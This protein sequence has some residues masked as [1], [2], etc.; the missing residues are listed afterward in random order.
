MKLLE[1]G[2]YRLYLYPTLLWGCVRAFDDPNV[3]TIGIGPFE[4]LIDPADWEETENE[5]G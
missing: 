4:L 3:W 2:R 5:R 1:I